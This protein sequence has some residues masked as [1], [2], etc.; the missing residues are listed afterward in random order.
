MDF[1]AEWQPAVKVVGR[2]P[3]ARHRARAVLGD[4]LG[5]RGIDLRHVDEADIR[6][7]EVVTPQGLGLRL[8]V[9]KKLLRRRQLLKRLGCR[10]RLGCR[11]PI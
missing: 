7:D 3:D 6:T 5:E 11:K 1:Y 4:W 8:S 2:V 10:A 9:R